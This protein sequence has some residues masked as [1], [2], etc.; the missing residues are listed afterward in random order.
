M[1]PVVEHRAMKVKVWALF[2]FR[3]SQLLMLEQ[4]KWKCKYYFYSDD[5]SCW[6]KSSESESVNNIF[7]WWSQLLILGQKVLEGGICGHGFICNLNKFHLLWI[8]FQHLSRNEYF[9]FKWASLYFFS[10]KILSYWDLCVG[11]LYSTYNIITV[12]SISPPTKQ[13]NIAQECAMSHPP[14]LGLVFWLTLYST[15]VTN[16]IS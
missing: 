13:K 10:K 2:S 14:D 1:I 16:H 5:P 8:F 9:S 6:S 15:T 12:N 7:I 11:P 3:W 4:W